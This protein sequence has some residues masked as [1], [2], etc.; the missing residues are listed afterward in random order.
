MSSTFKLEYVREEAG[1]IITGH[2][3]AFACDLRHWGIADGVLTAAHNVGEK[4]SSYPN[5][6]LEINGKKKG[7][8]VLAANP[9][10]DLA[11]LSCD[12]GI[13]P[14]KLSD[15]ELS[16]GDP[17][18]MTGLLKSNPVMLEYW[19]S[20]EGLFYQGFARHKIAVVF[21]HGASGGPITKSGKVVGI[22][23]CGIP[24]DGDL[25]RSCGLFVPTV[26]IKAFLGSAKR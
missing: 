13:K 10:L 1:A 16:I 11:V 6:T 26:A 24:K 5:L 21:D 20:I 19:G 23:V 17:V 18:V 9:E 7:C 2:G 25:D 12:T 4:G 15:E 14:L 22:A 8:K 3:T